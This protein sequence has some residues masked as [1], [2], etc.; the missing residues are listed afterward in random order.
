MAKVTQAD[1]Y[2]ENG[3]GLELWSERLL[4]GAG[5]PRI[6]PGQAGYL[7]ATDGVPRL[8]VPSEVT[9]AQGDLHPEGNP[10]VWLDPLNVAIAADNIAAGLARVDPANAAFYGERAKSFRRK[11]DERLF[12]ADLVGFMGGDLLER[13]ARGHTLL[14]FL[15]QKGLMG[16]LGGWY[17]SGASARG[18]PVVFY[19]QSWA[20]FIDRF[21]VDLVG[22]VEDVY[23]DDRLARVGGDE[24]GAEVVAIAGEVGGLPEATDYFAMIDA[25]L[26]RIGG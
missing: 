23:Y 12:G 14:P 9:R 25:L 3:M 19:H 1:L 24:V 16:R 2:I 10:H 11:I 13:L 5:N 26:A 20:Y 15:E 18:K 22:Y 21:G 8:E 7:K 4:D 17:A 6:R